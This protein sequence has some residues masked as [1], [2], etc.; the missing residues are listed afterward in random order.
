MKLLTCRQLTLACLLGACCLLR[1]WAQTP[2]PA[3]PDPVQAFL[4]PEA[5]A[6]ATLLASPALQAALKQKSA[7]LH[8]AQMTA[9]GSGEFSVRLTQQNRRVPLAGERFA[10][11]GISIERPVRW[12]GKAPL[13]A[14]LA[15]QSRQVAHIGYA[16]A[17]HEASR[18]LLRQWFALRRAQLDLDSAATGQALA[19][20]LHRQA[21]VRLKNGDVS[22]LD[23]QLAQAEWARAQA[24][25]QSAQAQQDSARIT[26][27]RLYPGLPLAM[28]WPDF[29]T[30]PEWPALAGLQST[31]LQH[32]HELN[33]W[34]AEVQRLHLLAERLDKDQRPDPT[35]GLY[36]MR[37]R[38]GAEQIVGVSLSLPL[39]GQARTRHALAALEEARS[40]Q[41]MLQQLEWQLGADFEARWTRL[42]HLRQVAR[43]LET[44]ARIQQA[45]ANKSVKAYAVGEHT[46]TELLQNQR[47]ASEQRRNS[48]LQ[49]LEAIELHALLALDLH[50][51]WDF[52]N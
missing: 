16:D 24:A 22:A 48:A 52:D 23:A 36:T 40:A 45:A 3:V 1:V 5:L 33:L 44:A 26:L 6:K 41:D 19:Q 31:F 35:L 15:E 27:A 17:L 38:Q 29:S 7:H 28:P 43:H 50:Q 49:Q 10:E 46:M 42:Q 8:R 21:Q 51:I 4:P 2:A 13:D 12:W 20:E 30:L 11:T 34:R 32:H 14:A 18:E 9:A 37:E 25:W 39:G 47:L